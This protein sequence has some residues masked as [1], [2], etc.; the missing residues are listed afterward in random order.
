MLAIVFVAISPQF[1][2][3]LSS[4]GEDRYRSGNLLSMS[5]ISML[6]SIALLFYLAMILRGY[7]VFGTTQRTFRDAVV[8]ALSGLNLKYQ[9]TL[10][11]IQLPTVGA[12]L[13]VAVQGWIGTGQLRLRGGDRPGLLAE[14]A[15][16]MKAYFDSKQVETNMTT[17]VA[18][19]IAG[20]LM[21]AMLVP[22]MLMVR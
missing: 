4:L 10:S 11:S 16:G 12:E 2:L 9:E 13:Q 1:I 19:V 15:S 21:G 5:L 14:V 8:A 22:L 6:V 20:I 18:Y 7:M 17:A 3:S